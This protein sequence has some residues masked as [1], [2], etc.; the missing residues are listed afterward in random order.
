MG[1][2]LESVGKPHGPHIGL[3]D[4]VLRLGAVPGQVDGQVMEG[5]QVLQGLVPELV[6]SHG[7]RE[8]G[9]SGAGSR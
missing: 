3:L 9:G 8:G 1:S 7:T 2:R 4:Q 6:V 5:V